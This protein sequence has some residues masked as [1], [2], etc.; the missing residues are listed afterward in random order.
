M[1]DRTV[2]ELSTNLDDISGLLDQMIT[3][4]VA[5]DAREAALKAEIA[6]LVASMDASAQA[7]SALQTKIDAAVEKSEGVE[8]KARAAL[9]GVPPVG[10]TPLL[11]SYADKAGFD[12]A[13]ASYTG[14][15]RVTL[16]GSDVKAGTDP[17]LDYF[18]QT[19]SSISTSPT[20]AP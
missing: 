11:Q 9:P 20:G 7:K 16:D 4:L 18:T 13:V 3:R 19:D 8:N 14:P 15:E 17:A 12:A 1:V 10:G 6:T 5:N 2:E